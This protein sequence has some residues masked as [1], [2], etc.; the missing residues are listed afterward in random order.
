VSGDFQH[1]EDAE[2]QVGL[3]PQ[4]P[5]HLHFVRSHGLLAQPFPQV[6]KSDTVFYIRRTVGQGERGLDRRQSGPFVPNLHIPAVQ[7]GS[8][9]ER[10]TQGGRNSHVE[11][12]PVIVYGQALASHQCGLVLRLQAQDGV[13]PHR[14]VPAAHGQAPG[15]TQIHLLADI[16]APLSRHPGE[17][18]GDL[19]APWG[20]RLQD[21]IGRA[22]NP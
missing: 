4:R 10:N 5:S 12:R 6:Q 14:L 22:Q 1:G 13:F 3:V 20:V 21:D 16:I 8:G 17:F 19:Q 11:G 9:R 15:L 2:G 18:L 7:A